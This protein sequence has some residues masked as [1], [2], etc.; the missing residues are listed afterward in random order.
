MAL[1]DTQELT[2]FF[3]RRVAAYQKG[4]QGEV[5]FD[6]SF[7]SVGSSIFFN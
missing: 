4:V 1:Q 5:S 2:N 7:L 3:E 6:E